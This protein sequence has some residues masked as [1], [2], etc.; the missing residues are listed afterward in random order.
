MRRAPFER[1]ASVRKFTRSRLLGCEISSGLTPCP[2]LPSSSP[3]SRPRP[4]GTLPV[5]W[6]PWW[7][8]KMSC[9]T[10]CGWTYVGKLKNS[11]RTWV[12]RVRT[13]PLFKTS[14]PKGPCLI[15]YPDFCLCL[16]T[17]CLLLLSFG[18]FC[19]ICALVGCNT[20]ATS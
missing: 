1:L 9:M 19:L 8:R 5:P 4:L 6:K 10:L 16:N 11:S 17:P 2:V 15:H 7:T 13:L 14:P 3:F 18:L 12:L 20:M